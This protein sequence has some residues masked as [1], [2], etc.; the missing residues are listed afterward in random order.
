MVVRTSHI[1]VAVILHVVVLGM[2]FVGFRCSKK[3]TPPPVIQATIV[4]TP[5]PAK[6]E[7]PKEDPRKI[8]EE[9]RKAELEK[10]KIEEQKKAEQEAKLKAKEDAKKKAAEDLKK[11]KEDAERKTKEQEAEKKKQQQKELESQL[12]QQIKQEESQRNSAARATA[13]QV[14]VAQIIE[15]VKRN[16]LQP[17][18]APDDFKCEVHVQLLPAGQVVGVTL[19]GTSGNSLVDESVRRAVL[20]SDPLPVPQDPSVFEREP[21]FTFTP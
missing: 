13:Q 3:V 16:W 12:N 20:K 6:P 15:K 1:V 19:A 11:K 5:A 18:G 21:N 9:K 7:P 4:G 10:Q 14:W 2:L 8:E 17:P